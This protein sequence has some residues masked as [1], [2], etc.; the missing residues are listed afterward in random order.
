MGKT[1]EEQKSKKKK[2][3]KDKA[4]AKKAEKTVCTCCGKHC[5]LS[6]PRCGKGKKL[7]AKLGF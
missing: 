3:E 7:A 6:K 2:K 4:K 1:K 5:P